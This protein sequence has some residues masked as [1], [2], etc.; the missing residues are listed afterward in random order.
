M[1]KTYRRFS[2][3]FKLGVIETYLAGHGSAKAIA[4][5]AGINHS[6]LHFWLWKYERGELS[7]EQP[8]QETWSRRKRR[9]PLSNGRWAS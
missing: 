9:S 4:N 1:S 6:L 2:T 8:S 3:E 7:V 5:A